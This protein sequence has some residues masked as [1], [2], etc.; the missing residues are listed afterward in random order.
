[1]GIAT[2]RSARSRTRPDRPWRSEPNASTAPAGIGPSGGP[3][4]PGRR[5]GCAP[6]ARSPGVPGR[7]SAG[8]RRPGRRWGARGR[9]CRWTAR[10]GPRS[11]PRPGSPRRGCRGAAGCRAG[12][13]A[14]PRPAP[15]PAAGPGR[16]ARPGRRPAVR[17]RPAHP[18]DLDPDVRRD[19]GQQRHRGGRVGRDDPIQHRPEPYGVLHRVHP[20][21]DD[22]FRHLVEVRASA[23][24]RPRPSPTD[25]LPVVHGG[26]RSGPPAPTRGRTGA[27]QARPRSARSYAA[28]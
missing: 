1:M 22:R 17:P 4:P 10:P 3:R 15:T 18:L 24:S 7:R 26:Q 12:P 8:R 11:R 19:R 28:R 6:A 23:R 13:S 14:R 25:G 9:P 2:T 21:Q 20:E 27:A 16:P 5:P